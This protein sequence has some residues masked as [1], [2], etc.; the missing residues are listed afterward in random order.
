M[1]AKH[2]V[3]MRAVTNPALAADPAAAL[4]VTLGMPSRYLAN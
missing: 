1:N 4:I 2:A 3:E